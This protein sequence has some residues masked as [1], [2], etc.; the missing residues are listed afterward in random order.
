MQEIKLNEPFT[1]EGKMVKIVEVAIGHTAGKRYAFIGSQ[2]GFNSPVI[3]QI[4]KER[5]FKRIGKTEKLQKFSDS[6]WNAGII[7]HNIW[8]EVTPDFICQ[9]SGEGFM[10]GDEIYS[11]RFD[12]YMDIQSVGTLSESSLQLK[13][14]LKY[15]LD[16]WIYFH[17]AKEVL[18]FQEKKFGKKEEEKLWYFNQDTYK[19][20]STTKGDGNTFTQYYTSESD[21]KAARDEW[22]YKNVLV[23]GEESWKIYL[24]FENNPRERNYMQV[25]VEYILNKGGR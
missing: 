11:C 19:I 17:T 21:C 14:D 18:D 5:W 10:I 23:S 20:E 25:F 8:T 7:D 6:N 1:L 24:E 13:P 4:K 12:I 22:V 16:N 3:D 15:L 9:H 2:A